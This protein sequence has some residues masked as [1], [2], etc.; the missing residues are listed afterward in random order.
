MPSPDFRPP[1]RARSAVA[2]LCLMCLFALS[3]AACSRPEAPPPPVRAVKLLTVGETAQQQPIQYAGVVAARSEAALGFRVAG[4]LLARPVV[5]GQAVRKGQLLAQ[6]DATDYE[7]SAAAAQAQLRAATTERDLQAADLQR[8]RE[9]RA[10]NF[11][12][13]AELDRRSAALK[14]A[15][16]RVEQARAQLSAQG[17]QAEYTRLVADADAVVTATLAEPGQVVAAGTPV[18]RLALDGAREVRFAVPEQRLAQVKVGQE[19]TVRAWADQQTPQAARVR[20]IAAS[21]DPA[22]RT[23]A[24]KLEILGAAQPP[25]GATVTVDWP[26]AAQA[27][28]SIRLPGTAIWSDEAGRSSVW[29]YEPGSSTVQRRHVELGE[30][31]GNQWIVRSGLQAGERLVATGAHVLQEG[32]KVRIFE[33]PGSGER[34]AAEP[35]R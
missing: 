19:V 14:A 22:T 1:L 26:R 2:A 4:K 17:N 13:A 10:Q 8:Y 23:F 18:V 3:L 28:P 6:L 21:A 25:L 30:A 31:D 7:L 24:V 15:Q 32:E 5:Q 33:A 9:L 20:E 35:T 16:S 29:V 11:I 34:S 27:Q 12:S